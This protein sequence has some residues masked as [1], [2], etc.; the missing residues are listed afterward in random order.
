MSTQL[1]A[2]LKKKCDADDNVKILLSQWE[3]D[4]KLVGKA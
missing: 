4:Q 2:H 1:I 3:F